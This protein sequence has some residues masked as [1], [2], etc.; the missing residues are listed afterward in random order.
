MTSIEL[1]SPAKDLEC[2]KYAILSGADAVYIGYSRFGARSSAGNSLEDI[3][4]LIDFAHQ[5]YAKVYITINTLLKDNELEEAWKLIQQLYEMKVDGI[6]IQDTGLLQMDLPPIPIIASTQMHNASLDKVLFLEKAGFSRV[7]LARELSL[8]EIEHISSNTSIELEAFIHGALCVCYSGQC[9]LSYAIGGRSGNRGNC[10]QPCRKK[11]SLIDSNGTV[12]AKD[13]HLLSL[14]DMNRSNHIKD[15]ILAGVTSFKIEG[16]LKDSAYIKNVVSF[17]REKIDRVLEDLQLSKSSSGRSLIPFIPDLNKTFNRAYTDYC[18]TGNKTGISSIETPKATG[19]FIGTIIS[20]T[21]NAFSIKTSK[22]LTAGDG[23]C[24]FD[25]KNNLCGTTIQKVVQNNIFP[26]EIDHI[27]KGQKV[28]RNYDHQFNKE[29]SKAEIK[30]LIDVRFTLTSTESSFI[31]TATDENNNSV[32]C[33]APAGPETAKN[34]DMLIDNI[35]KQLSKLGDSIFHLTQ[36]ELKVE[37]YPFAPVKTLNDLRRQAIEKL[38]QQREQNRPILK[39]F[40]VQEKATYPEKTLRYNTNVLNSRARKFYETCGATVVE[41]AAESGL[42]LSGKKLMTTKHCLKNE[43]N[44]CQQTSSK[45]KESFY[46]IDE[47]GKRYPLKFNCK[48]CVME[49]YEP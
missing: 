35:R 25:S 41:M 31:L 46:L 16:R 36:L 9:Y 44:L 33:E 5:Y 1:L 17:Y 27:S 23:I 43:F 49:I 3:A 10:A 13:K 24:F 28:F 34:K 39:K 48:S 47:M 42:E 11:Y 21:K 26:K 8:P 12:I 22:Q 45:Y 20:V 6:I 32:T 2:G 14:K 38:L 19:E 4:T 29:L 30:R 40:V 18:L 7:I 15:L 37:H